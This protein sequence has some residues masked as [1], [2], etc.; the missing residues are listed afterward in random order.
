MSAEVE[1]LAKTLKALADFN[2]LSIVMS[3][4]KDSRS[5]TEIINAT[6]LSQT[7][8]SFHLRALRNA[9]IVKTRREGPFIYYSLTEP[10]LIDVLHDLSMAVNS[11]EL[12]VG[13]IFD[14]KPAGLLK[15]Q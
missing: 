10:T 3:I 9:G 4:S 13:Q 14:S 12:I 1:K 8:V 6:G 2:R 7:L 5:V 11:T 15:K